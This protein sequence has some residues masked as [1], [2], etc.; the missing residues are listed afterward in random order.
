MSEMSHDL[1][2]EIAIAALQ[3]HFSTE[4]KLNTIIAPG[5]KK[6]DGDR[7][8]AIKE[9]AEDLADRNGYGTRVPYHRLKE[10]A[11]TKV[12]HF[13][14]EIWAQ[15]WE[16]PKGGPSFAASKAAHKGDK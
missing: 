14:D 11:Y 16:K 5:L 6:M 12:I 15:S 7:L 10:G 2:E 13:A 4:L 8:R 3:P 9:D 1:A